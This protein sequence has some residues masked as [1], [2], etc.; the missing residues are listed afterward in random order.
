MKT[1]D[2]LNIPTLYTELYRNDD[3]VKRILMT[4]TVGTITATSGSAS[5]TVSDSSSLAVGYNLYQDDGTAI[6]TVASVGSG[7][8]TLTSVAPD[9]Y[10]GVL[11]VGIGWETAV[12]DAVCQIRTKGSGRLI[13]DLQLGA[14]ISFDVDW[15]ELDFTSA[16]TTVRADLYWGDVRAVLLD[17]SYQTLIR[18]EDN[19]VLQNKSELNA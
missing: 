18:I 9:N 17:G 4:T 14:G 6:G 7:T 16:K 3:A 12:S 15:M 11:K 13:I 8:A 5:V 2:P 10:T 1:R 19:K